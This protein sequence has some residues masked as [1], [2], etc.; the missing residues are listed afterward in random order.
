MLNIN[1]GKISRAIK[2]V[3]YGTEGIGKSTLAAQFPGALF[4]D[5]EGGTAQMDVR[6]I[7]APKTWDELLSD[8]REVAQNPGICET[9]ILDTADFSE[10]MLISHICKKHNQKGIE[11]FGYGKGYTYV[12]EEWQKLMA[13]FD[14]VIRAGMN[15]TVIAHARQRKIEL[16]DQAGA[17]DHWEMKLTKQV[18]PLLKE[19]ADL[20]LFCNYKTYVVTTDNDTKKAQGGKRVMYTSHN[21]VYD[22]KNRHGLPE[23]LP[24]SFEGIAGIFSNAECGMQNSE[25]SPLE[26]LRG[27]MEEAGIAEDEL[28]RIAAEK[29]GVDPEL[30]LEA[31]SEKFVS[32]WCIKYFDKIV[33]MIKGEQA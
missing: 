5:A 22:A 10:Q 12:G 30:P 32:G 29:R 23:E 16:P 9:L 3:I 24:L 28:R 26:K 18:A 17:F 21:P 27:M 15:V 1:S 19:W 14:A 2:T 6:R 11:S 8:V 20:L 33:S 13:A 31:Y 25:L 4:I 7:E